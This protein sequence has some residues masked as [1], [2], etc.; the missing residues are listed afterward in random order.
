MNSFKNFDNICVK[1]GVTVPIRLLKRG[2]E[3]PGLKVKDKTQENLIFP[4]CYDIEN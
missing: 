1:I 4:N 3:A 2:L